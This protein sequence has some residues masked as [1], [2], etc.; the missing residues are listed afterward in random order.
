MVNCVVC[1]TDEKDAFSANQLKK[2]QSQPKCC[3]SCMELDTEDG[4]PAI[5]EAQYDLSSTAASGGWTFTG[6]N[7]RRGLTQIG[8]GASFDYEKDDSE[9]NKMMLSFCPS[10][11]TT[12]SNL[13]RED[14]TELSQ[15]YR[16]VEVGEI[17]ELL[18]VLLQNPRPHTGVGYYWKD[19]SESDGVNFGKLEGGG[20]NG[21]RTGGR[22]SSDD[23][24]AR[25]GGGGGRSN[26]KPRPLSYF[27]ENKL[28]EDCD[29]YKIGKCYFGEHCRRRHLPQ[30]I[31][32]IPREKSTEVCMNFAKGACRFGDLCHRVH[33]Q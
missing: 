3:N 33:E 11:G 23:G 22:K 5:V 20:G 6:T 27:V 31:Q 8:R 26:R 16:G 17:K 28:D 7:C 30:G 14:A 24:E 21:R 25:G 4:I 19:A 18:H 1:D 2:K 12:R 32:P 9:G 10:T 15:L 13:T 29:L